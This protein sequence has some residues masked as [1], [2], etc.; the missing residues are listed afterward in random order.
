MLLT[1]RCNFSWYTGGGLSFV[2]MHAEPGVASLLVTRDR[3][4]CLSTNIEAGRLAD[5]ELAG[6]GIESVAF[7]WHDADATASVL[8]ETVGS[9][10]VAADVPVGGLPANVGAMPAGF[11][12]LRWALT[13]AEVDR[14]RA[15]GREVAAVVERTCRQ[16][17]PG[18]SE[19]ELAARIVGGLGARAIRTWVCLVAADERI[20]RYRHPI[21]TDRPIDK[22]VMAVACGERGGLICSITRL[23]SF[24]PVDDDRAARHRAVCAVDAAMIDATR[25]GQTLGDVWEAT[26]K[27]Y[28][29]AGFADEW[30]HHH[31]GGPT[32]Y[33]SRE[34]KATPGSTLPVL[35]PQAYAWNP[36]IAGTK[37]EDTVLCTADK[38]EVL[39]STDSW[40]TIEVQTSGGICRRADILCR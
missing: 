10:K 5:E 40:P 25:P 1:R 17:E 30:K 37:S 22:M 39:T 27:A 36:S 29:E 23:V 16:C 4:V 13:E 7:P 8:A 3:T 26:V 32:G 33:L 38:P 2:N 34:A 9:A 20:A 12:Q 6:L 31:Q 14:Y 18:Q 11:D 28:A 19:H 21:P 24:G 35:G 15:L